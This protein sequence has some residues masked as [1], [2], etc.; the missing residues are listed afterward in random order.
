[1]GNA[2][3]ASLVMAVGISITPLAI[4][5]VL[6][7]LTT[8]RARTN[9]L[10]FLLGW[11]IGL[12]VVGCVVLVIFAP[13]HASH[14]G[15]PATWVSWLRLVLGGFLL[16]VPLYWLGHRP[17][18]N[19]AVRMP[20]WLGKVD[21]VKPPMALALGTVLA[22][23]RPK[24]LLLIVAG[25]AAIAQTGIPAAQQAIAYI[26]FAAVATI[27]VGIP[28]AIYFVTRQRAPDVLGRLEDWM[29]Y[30]AVPITSVVCLLIGADLI[31]SAIS[32][33]SGA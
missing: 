21:H 19:D 13:A 31:G 32:A 7:L 2:I 18:R 30:G 10:A 24:N 26:V 27:G 29:S 28:V 5:A 4:T 15:T 17:G 1:M 12:G 16:V 11:L 8:P 33:L 23:V 20:A 3:G 14:S 9:G 6:L 25:A 22:G